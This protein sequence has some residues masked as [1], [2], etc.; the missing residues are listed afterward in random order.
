[1]FTHRL[2]F[3]QLLNG[4]VLDYNAQVDQSSGLARATITHVELRSSP[5][6][7]PVKSNYLQ[8]I[9]MKGALTEMINQDCVQI[10]KEQTAGNYDTADHMLKSLAARFRNLVELCIAWYVKSPYR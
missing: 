4:C 6:G 1:M 5:L 9:A 7:H 8:R 10:K 2:A 3:A